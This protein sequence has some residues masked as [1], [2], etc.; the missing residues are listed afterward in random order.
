V[1]KKVSEKDRLN[2]YYG[3]LS[4]DVVSVRLLKRGSVLTPGHEVTPGVLS[5]IKSLSAD[6]SVTEKSSE[7]QRRLKLAEWIVD[8]R[9]ALPSRVMVN[10][11]WGWL[12]GRGI[13][14]TPSDFGFNGARPSHPELLDRMASDFVSDGRS[15]KRLVK[16][17]VLSDA[18]RRGGEFSPKAAAADGDNQLLWRFSTRR[19]QAEEVR[20]SILTVSGRL[21][22]KQGGPS[23][24]LF[25]WTNNAGTLYRPVDKDTPET[26]RRSVYRMVVRGAEDPVLTS[27]DCPDPSIPVARR[28]TTT[29]ALQ[30]LSL[31]NNTFVL[32]EAGEF[33][34][35]LERESKTTEERIQLSYRL[36]FGRSPS[37]K[38]IARANGFVAKHGLKAWC[39]VL[40]NANEFLY[41]N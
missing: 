27:F 18:F 19:L 24:P 31:L 26:R 34:K 1:Q 10:R 16:R 3:I 35:R 32:R 30:A 12:F 17:I 33:A 11:V 7:G 41:V 38:E 20:D 29:T 5:A 39:R 6:L 13:V 23:F 28:Q 14:A 8:D 37:E 25:E 4:K 21:D 15:I 9:N 36:A 2:G 22:L 40:F